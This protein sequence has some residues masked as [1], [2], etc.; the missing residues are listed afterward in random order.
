MRLAVAHDTYRPAANLEQVSPRRDRDRRQGGD[1][2][3]KLPARPHGIPSC[4]V[5]AA[6]KEQEVRKSIAYTRLEENGERLWVVVL[7]EHT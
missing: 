7:F 3:R 6:R 2:P 1:S 5:L 4:Q